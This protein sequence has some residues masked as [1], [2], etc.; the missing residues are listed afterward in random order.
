MHSTAGGTYR[1]FLTYCIYISV[2][3]CFVYCCYLC[4]L[5]SITIWQSDWLKPKL[6]VF[7]YLFEFA[8][9]IK[10]FRNFFL[11]RIRWSKQFDYQKCTHHYNKGHHFQLKWNNMLIKKLLKFNCQASD[12]VKNH[13]SE[14]QSSALWARVAHVWCSDCSRVYQRAKFISIRQTLGVAQR[15]VQQWGK[16]WQGLHFLT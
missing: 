7:S 4:Y 16:S 3:R 14:R 8:F 12:T 6:K 10:F 9:T 11:I 1:F 5:I 13:V 15:W 2:L